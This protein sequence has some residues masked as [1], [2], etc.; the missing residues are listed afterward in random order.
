M[1]RQPIPQPIKEQPKKKPH[2]KILEV[3]RTEHDVDNMNRWLS[4]WVTA[5]KNANVSVGSKLT[6][7][8]V[9]VR[10][11]F[12]RNETKI[13]NFHRISESWI[14]ITDWDWVSSLSWV[15]PESP[16]TWELCLC[17]QFSYSE[18]AWES[19]DKGGKYFWCISMK[20]L[21]IFT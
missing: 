14:F 11:F 5:F 4:L 21:K 18:K 8:V 13:F 15:R 1:I 6:D 17:F 12:R 20:N 19:I 3:R 10:V 9:K 16:E 2:S 7:F